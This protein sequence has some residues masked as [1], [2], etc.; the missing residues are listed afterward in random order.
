MREEGEVLKR[1]EGYDPIQREVP[2][3]PPESGDG[4]LRR[5]LAL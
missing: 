2:P 3:T 4:I 1:R 5:R